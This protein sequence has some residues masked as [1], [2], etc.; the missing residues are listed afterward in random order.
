MAGVFLVLGEG[1]RK[2][3]LMAPAC[4]Q[5][6]SYIREMEVLKGALELPLVHG[7]FST[8]A[9]TYILPWK[10]SVGLTV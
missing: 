4:L 8:E 5:L 9:D 7:P 3:G 6:L 1:L 2:Q 10:T